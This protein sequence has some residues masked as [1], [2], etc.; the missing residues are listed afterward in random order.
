[1][2]APTTPCSQRLPDHLREQRDHLNQQ[3]LP[4]AG[5]QLFCQSTSISRPPDRRAP[6]AVRG[7]TQCSR[8]P[9]PPSPPPVRPRMAHLAQ[10][11]P[12]RLRTLKR[13]DRP[14]IFA[15]RRRRSSGAALNIP[16]RSNSAAF[17]SS[18]PCS[19]PQPASVEFSVRQLEGARGASRV[20]QRPDRSAAG[21]RRSYATGFSGQPRTPWRP[22]LAQ[23]QVL[24]SRRISATVPPQAVACLR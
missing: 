9:G 8:A 22:S 4:T 19:Y 14:V 2:R 23:S 24:A 16:P 6:G 20:A 5:L 3:H 1:M 13:A 10:L 18:M 11:R 17:R 15:R 12:A 7:R 21:S